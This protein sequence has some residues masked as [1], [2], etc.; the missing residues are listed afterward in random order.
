M[1]I[2]DNIRNIFSAYTSLPDEIISE[3][4]QIGEYIEFP[5]NSVL[6]KNNIKETN[7]R[8]ILKGCGGFFIYN[9]GDEKLVYFIFENDFLFDYQS[10]L[11]DTKT[12]FILKTFEDTQMFV[13]SKNKFIEF[14]ENSFYGEKIRRIG[15]ELLYCDTQTYYLDL[16]TL[17]ATERYLQLLSKFKGINQRIDNKHIASFL[18][19]TPQSLSRLRKSLLKK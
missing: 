13:I 19:I 15:A 8:L 7:I 11:F 1:K 4:L 14:T 5:K 2:E 10:L 6:K 17:N 12:D 9:N 3:L 16:L 18:G